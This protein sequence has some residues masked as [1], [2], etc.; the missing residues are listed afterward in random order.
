MF[1]HFQDVTT[2]VLMVGSNRVMWTK[3]TVEGTHKGTE[4]T[5]VMSELLLLMRTHAREESDT[6][7][8]YCKI[9]FHSVLFMG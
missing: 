8:I 7:V 1:T 2:K 6:A 4:E 9:L 5:R 3:R